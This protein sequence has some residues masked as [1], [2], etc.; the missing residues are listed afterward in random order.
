MAEYKNVK[1]MS[2]KEASLELN[3]IVHSLENGDLE[4]EESL[5]MYGR[6][7]ELLKDLHNRLDKAE[8]QVAVI[9]A[10]ENTMLDVPGF[11]PSEDIQF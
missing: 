6:G 1:D 3:S 9:L 11:N 10:D 5:E 8:Q 4:L 2:F 7:V